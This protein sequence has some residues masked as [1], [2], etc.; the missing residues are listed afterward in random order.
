MYEL[1]KYAYVTV[2]FSEKKCKNMLVVQNNY[3]IMSHP[4]TFPG[5]TLVDITYEMG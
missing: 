2:L 4:I 3:K 5:S 1:S